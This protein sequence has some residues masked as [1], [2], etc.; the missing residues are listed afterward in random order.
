MKRFAY[1]SLVS[2]LLLVSNAATSH[3]E[4]KKVQMKIAGYLCG[5]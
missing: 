5:N 1:A 3:A 2:F 4:V